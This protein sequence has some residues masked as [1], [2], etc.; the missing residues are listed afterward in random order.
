MK[1]EII[2][3]DNCSREKGEVNH[4]YMLAPMI[5]AGNEI[6]TVTRWSDAAIENFKHACGEKCAL[7]MASRWMQSGKLIADK[8]DMGRVPES[9]A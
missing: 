1:R 3:C 6:I 7:E 4:W 8:P 9:D 2:L 5:G